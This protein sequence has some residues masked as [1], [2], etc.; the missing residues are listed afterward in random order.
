VSILSPL[1][2]LR[3][4]PV[5]LL[6]RQHDTPLGQQRHQTLQQAGDLPDPRDAQ[7]ARLKTEIATLKERLN[8]S[9]N[10]IDNLTDLCGQ[11]LARLAAQHDEITR[12][13]GSMAAAGRVSQLPRRGITI[14]SCS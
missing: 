4:Q 5:H 10:T 9:A 1:Q 7:I 12:L 3:H 8:Q 13:R 6:A 2:W 14:G 11:A